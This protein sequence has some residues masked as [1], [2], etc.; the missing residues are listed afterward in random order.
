[1][2][3]LQVII[4]T[5]RLVAYFSFPDCSVCKSLRQKIEELVE[6]HKDTEFVYIDTK[7]HPAAGGQYLVF[8]APT[9]IYFEH[10]KERKRWS[11]VFSVSDVESQLLRKD[12]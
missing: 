9:V 4:D 12:R 6:K 11:R 2:D 10:G 7:T 8:A 5:S 1:M 3:P